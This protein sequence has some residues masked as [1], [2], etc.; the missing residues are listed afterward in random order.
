MC[1]IPSV[2]TLPINPP[3]VRDFKMLSLIY[4]ARNASGVHSYVH[5]MCPENLFTINTYVN[6]LILKPGGVKCTFLYYVLFDNPEF[7]ITLRNFFLDVMTSMHLKD[8]RVTV[9]CM[10]N[11]DATAS[12]EFVFKQGDYIVAS[13]MATAVGVYRCPDGDDCDM[14]AHI[15]YWLNG[16]KMP[17]N[18]VMGLAQ[19]KNLRH[20]FRILEVPP[21]V[22]GVLHRETHWEYKE[23]TDT[24][25]ILNLK[26]LHKS[27][28]VDLLSPQM[29]MWPGDWALI[30]GKFIQYTQKYKGIA[31]GLTAFYYAGP[32][33][34]KDFD[35][36]ANTTQSVTFFISVNSVFALISTDD[37]YFVSPPLMLK[38]SCMMLLCN[39]LYIE[40]IE[41]HVS[42]I[43]L[44]PLKP[45]ADARKR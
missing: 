29:F 16:T 19:Y 26:H 41:A 9:K 36:Y 13:I 24:T 32:E 31:V 30:T 33:T 37:D 1:T 44:P 27:R 45:P 4:A 43:H 10:G 17:G 40:N 38:R 11:T 8:R 25:M 14:T 35:V 42:T 39:N 20:M 5:T 15:E 21:Y 6:K 7:K 28:F 34:L 22:D 2:G 12:E 18:F 3:P 23:I